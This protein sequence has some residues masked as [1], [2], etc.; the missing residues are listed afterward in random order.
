MRRSCVLLIALALVLP[1]VALAQTPRP[2][3][4]GRA[5]TM[6]DGSR[7]AV[8]YGRPYMK[9]RTVWGGTLVPAGQI[10]RLGA[11]EATLLV[12]QAPIE[13]GGSMVPAGAHTLFFWMNAD[14]TA[15]LVINKQIGQWGLQYDQAQDLARV[16]LK[17]ETLPSPVEQLTLAVEKNP[18]GGGGLITISWDT[19]KWSVPFVVKK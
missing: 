7:V 5:S 13:L 12:T 9:G 6:V 15:K 16:D 1:S 10:W 4:D 18:A 19:V 2:S 17:K 3:P 14:G 11:N 8:V